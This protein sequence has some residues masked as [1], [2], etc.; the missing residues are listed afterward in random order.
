MAGLIALLK[1]RPENH[2]TH[3]G[4][5]KTEVEAGTEMV[6]QAKAVVQMWQELGQ[7]LQQKVKDLECRITVLEASEQAKAAR[8]NELE[9]TNAAKDKRIQELEREVERLQQEV[10]VLK[11]AQGINI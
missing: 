6:D 10:K 5:I 8:I 11:E 1:V 3:A 4:A 9:T 7:Q 2:A